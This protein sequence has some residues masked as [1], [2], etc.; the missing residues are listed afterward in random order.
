MELLNVDKLRQQDFL[1]KKHQHKN[2]K[3]KYQSSPWSHGLILK[4]CA[5]LVHNPSKLSQI[6]TPT[7][8][9]KENK[10]KDGVKCDPSASFF[11]KLLYGGSA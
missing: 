4:I 3:F 10:S 6:F 7:G 1:Q 5:A 9:E 2:V 11:V 8:A